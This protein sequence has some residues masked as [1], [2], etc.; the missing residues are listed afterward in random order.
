MAQKT[1]TAPQS[2]DQA[3]SGS[4]T[5]SAKDGTG[6]GSPNSARQSISSG[7]VSSSTLPRISDPTP[8]STSTK[9][10]SP[11]PPPQAMEKP[12]SA[13]GSQ[14][15]PYGTR[16]RN[17]TGAARPNYAEDKDLD[18]D[19]FDAYPQRKEDDPKKSGSTKQQ[20]ASSTPTPAN[21]SQAGAPRSGNGSS[22]KPL[23][24]EGRHQNGI[25]DQQN[26]SQRQSPAAA[27]SSSI[28]NGST[29]TTTT[30]TANGSSKGKKRKV[31]DT[32]STA[33][34]SQTPLGPNGALSSS[35]LQKRLGT[36]GQGSGDGT[37][38]VAGYGETNLL[39]FENCKARPKDG[40]M[41][42]DDGTV[43]EVN[44]EFC[45]SAPHYVLWS[46]LTRRCRSCVP[47]V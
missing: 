12:S 14:P 22:R 11:Q 17:R 23:P 7:A 47:G 16:S 26:Q 6:P 13:A 30:T 41:I 34:G 39:T 44:G 19:I 38:S 20:G 25:K 40:K 3:N 35:V 42:A 29:T 46:V 18:L 27:L 36:A 5:S 10:E 4:R 37:P 2:E 33:S 21:S 31:A 1:Q 15:S 43:L 45:P 9:S 8:N 28:A 24:D 32:A